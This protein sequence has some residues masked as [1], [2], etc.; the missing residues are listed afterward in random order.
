[1]NKKTE[2]IIW[3]FPWKYAE[4]FI[5]TSTFVIMGFFLDLFSSS[6]KNISLE[7]PINIILLS[8]FIVVLI[9]VSI[10][11]KKSKILEWFSSSYLT[12]ATILWLLIMVIAMGSITQDIDSKVEIINK[13]RLNNIV[14]STPF[15]ILEFFLLANLGLVIIK[16][17]RD[18]NL[19]DSF[20]ILNHLGIFITV[21]ALALSPS[22]LEKYTIKLDKDNYTWQVKTKDHISDLPFALQL[23]DFK[24]EAF[25]PK[26]AIVENA[27]DEIIKGN[28]NVISLDKDSLIEYNDIKITVK[29]YLHRALKSGSE[30]YLINQQ[31]S[32][33]ATFLQVEY[34]GIT[35]NGW[36]TCGSYIY[37][38]QFLEIDSNYTIVMLEPEAKS[39]KS[40]IRIIHKNSETEI[41][42]VE[43]NNPIQVNGWDIYQTD[44]NRTL[45]NLSDYSVIE[46]VK[47]PWLN[48]IY[49]GIFMMIFGASLMI[50]IGK[51]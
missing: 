33:P 13:L 38:S 8:I 31:G 24:M 35:K 19:T 10:I 49:I 21:I 42:T 29:K 43:V 9:A 6:N 47:D 16:R 37:S 11:L 17:F 39:F 14:Y 20:F 51:R 28:K 30:Y 3:E 36:V 1:M 46:M 2:N 7:F 48:V 12:I 18:I 45:G 26:I 5:I 27:T 44:Y 40:D 23:V 4:S 50:F 34:K 15:I 32:A 22:D 25:A 41:I